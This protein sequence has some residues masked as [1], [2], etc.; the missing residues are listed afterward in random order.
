M[1]TI[2]LQAAGAVLGGVLGPVGSAIGSAVGALAGYAIDRALID[3]TRHVEGPRLNGARPFTAEEGA[4]IPRVYGS[5][6]IGGTLIWATRFEEKRTTQRQG[7]KG[8][9]QSVTEY[10]YFANVAFALCEG[11]IAG[12]RRIW[13]DGREID[14]ND[15]EVRIYRGSK[16]QPVDP[17]IEA[18][19]GS[20]NAPAYRGLAYVVFERFALGDYGNRIPQ[21]QFEVLRPVGETV[22]Q[23]RAVCLIPGATEYGLS[24]RL[25][26]QQKRPGDS[27]A[28]N[29]HVLYAGTNLAASLD[30]LQMLCPNLEHVALVA[31]WFGDDL[32]AG[33]CRIRPMVTSRTASGFSEAWSSSGVSM[34]AAAAVS[35]SHGGPAYGGTPSDRSIIAAI[36]EIKARG[37]KV[38]LYPFVMMDIAAGNTLPDPYGGAAQAAYPWRGRITSHPA[39]MRPGSADR[40]TAARPQ[41]SAFCGGAVRSQ[42]EATAGGVRFTGA[43]D[44]WG[45]RR[46]LLHFAHL[47]A[48][49]DGVDAFLI[50]TELRGLTTLRD[51]ND[52]FPFVEA[53]CALAADVR[54]ILGAGT[55]I[56]YG[57]DW[58]EYFGHQPAGGSGDV[59]FHL[60]ALWAHPVVDAVGIDNYM[61]LSDWRDEDY[62]GPNPDGF[63]DP[64]DAAAMGEAIAGGEGY[65]WYYP[66]SEARLRRERAPITDGSHGKPWVYRYK[67]LAGWWSN[68]HYDRKGGQE[69]QTPTAWVPCSKPIWFTELGCPAVD[70]GPNQPNVFPD[71]KS[72]ENAIPYFSNGG[73]SDL[74]QQRFFG[75]HARHWNPK[76]AAFREENNPLSSLYGGRMVDTSRIYLWA[77]DARPFPAFPLRTDIWSDG[78]TWNRGHWLNGRLGNPSVAALIDRILKDHGLPPA[79]TSGADGTVQGYVIADPGAARAALEPIVELF[80]IAVHEAADRLVF[81][82][83]GTRIEAPVEVTELVYDGKGPIIETARIPDHQLPVEGILAFRDPLMEYQAGTVRSVREGAAGSRQ[84]VISFPGVLENSEGQALL[85]DWMRRIWAER[86]SI[87][88]AVATPNADVVPGNVVRFAGTGNGSGFLVTEIEDGLVRKVSARQI[89]QGAPAMWRPQQIVPS[90]PAPP[91]VGQPFVQLLDLP[92]APGGGAPED[93]FRIAVWQKPWKGQALFV[94]PEETGFVQRGSIARPASVGRLAGALS[95]G[96]EGRIDRSGSVLVELFDAEVASASRLQMLNGANAAAIRSAN[97]AWEVVQFQKAE[98][99]APDVWRLNDLLRGQL[100]T[101]DAMAV[102]AP[103]GASFVVLDDAVQPAGLLAREIGLSLNWRVGPFGADFSSDR[104]A[105][106]T[107]V[108]GLRARGPLSPVHLRARKSADGDLLLSWVRRGRI[109]ADDWSVGEIPLGEER[110]EYRIEIAAADG[111]PIRTANVVEPSWR[112]P[113]SLIAA[114]LG[115]RPAEIEVKISQFSVAAGWG[116]PLVRRLVVH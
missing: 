91:I 99:I 101:D 100:G 27:S 43:A 45:Y 46:F 83:R 60:D 42:F 68:R 48:A 102:G 116:I 25:V 94:S 82:S 106:V 107:G 2:L 110:E 85:D 70:K 9:G 17:L 37:L 36:R 81:R 90:I 108:G 39:P 98:E 32:R 14:R 51:Q 84:Q 96:F 16:D 26:T 64:Y 56:T 11:E 87:T 7:S 71:P 31:T 62:S 105:T 79:D 97:G 88:F 78:G 10:S 4:S 86:E 44:D 77:W 59:Y 49:A 3:S 13:A 18:K 95:P 66:S 53:L 115:V 33:Q 35:W 63:R 80:D 76:D 29:R 20:G 89:I 92:T 104:F 75:A 103:A 19:Q 65:D 111:R 69:A 67:D 28:A 50:G 74:A 112:Y 93:Q 12:V 57:A 23:V 24:P 34:D 54:A 6:R 8:G 109:D 41:V 38:T 30:E 15:F 40:T 113:A 72:V 61:P 114:D 5:A 73:R 47:A 55:A 22:R 21:F 52:A 1:A 58:S